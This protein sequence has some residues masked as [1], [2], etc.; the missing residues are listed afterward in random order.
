MSILEVLPGMGNRV[1][2]VGVWSQ[3]GGGTLSLAKV[4]VLRM[5]ELCG[6]AERVYTPLYFLEQ[7]ITNYT[8][9]LRGCRTLD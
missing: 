2:P 3:K 5:I 6:C 7:L 1:L 4:S 9:V 8:C